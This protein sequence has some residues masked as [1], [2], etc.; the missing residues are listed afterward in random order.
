MDGSGVAHRLNHEIEKYDHAS[1]SLITWINLPNLSAN[2]DTIMY[3][4]YGNQ[5]AGIQS[6]PKWVWINHFNAVWHLN[7]LSDST[8]NNNHGKNHGTTTL[9]GK[10]GIAT[11]FDGIN[12]YIEISNNPSINF[13]HTNKFSISLWL[14]NEQAT[15]Q[16]SESIISKGTGAYQRGY[17]L[18]IRKNTNLLGMGIKD[19]S[20]G[21]AHISSQI[22]NENL[23][24]HIVAIWDG[25]TLYTYINGE[26]DNSTYHG[27]VQ[28]ADDSKILEIGNHYGYIDNYHPLHGSIDELRISD[29]IRNPDWIKTEYNN[30]INPNMFYTVGLEETGP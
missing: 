11:S 4:Y 22:I 1:G 26:F 18:Y 25:T 21:Y 23:W 14:F 30:Q 29:T 16:K 5:Y 10:I 15:A 8:E 19:G 2:T 24:T 27:S 12:D 6:I 28:L 13:Q 7:N 3:M 9:S 17:N 20:I